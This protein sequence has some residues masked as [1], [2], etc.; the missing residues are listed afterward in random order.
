VG[1]FALISIIN[2]A[3]GIIACGPAKGSG[4][5]EILGKEAISPF[6]LFNE[7]TKGISRG[8]AAGRTGIGIDRTTVGDA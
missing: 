4:T 2:S 7:S 6:R 5:I 1:P 3:V 8:F